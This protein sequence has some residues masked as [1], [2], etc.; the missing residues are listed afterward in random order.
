MIW[1][2][3]VP[4]LLMSAV[5]Q[6]SLLSQIRFLGGGIDLALV[7]V[8]SWS[9]L[10][11]EEGLAWGAIAGA[12]CDFLSG[13]PFGITPIAFVLAAFLAGQLH[14]RL[15]I[16]SPLAIMVVTLIGTIVSQATVILFLVFFNYSLDIFYALL[17]VALPTTFLNMVISVPIYLALH[18]LH[19]GTLPPMLAV[20]EEE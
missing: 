13:G 14:G 10:R 11:P 17:Y 9:L 16:T 15:W 6:S 7:L 1:F 12:F 5:V 20:E 2:L 3:S 4:L 19:K 8:I 18:R